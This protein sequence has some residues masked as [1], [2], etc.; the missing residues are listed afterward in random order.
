MEVIDLLRDI[1]PLT[2]A[3]AEPFQNLLGIGSTRPPAWKRLGIL[4]FGASRTRA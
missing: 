3:E 1:E 2:D 4:F